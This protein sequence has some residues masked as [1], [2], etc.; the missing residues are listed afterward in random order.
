MVTSGG[1]IAAV[2]FFMPWVGMSCSGEV[3]ATVSPY[4]RSVGLNTATSE[5]LDDPRVQSIQ[6]L[7]SVAAE[8]VYWLLLAIPGLLALVG[9]VGLLPGPQG[10]TQ[11]IVGGFVGAILGISIT[12]LRGLRDKLDLVLQYQLGPDL[13]LQT[14]TEMGAWIAIA[15]YSL[16]LS[17]ALIAW[18]DRLSTQRTQRSL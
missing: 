13:D 15:G 10:S 11:L 6:G 12:V 5:R 16:A 9:A 3:I 2:A 14:T 8:P 1:L 7:D 17:G 4:D 18:V